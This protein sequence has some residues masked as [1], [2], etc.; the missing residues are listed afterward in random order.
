MAYYYCFYLYLLGAIYH[1]VSFAFLFWYVSY[2]VAVLL[3][4]SFPFKLRPTEYSNWKPHLIL[5]L[6]STFVPLFILVIFWAADSKRY[7]IANHPLICNPQPIPIVILFVMPVS[8]TLGLSLTSVLLIISQLIINQLRIGRHKTS[9]MNKKQNQFI[10]RTLGV[11]ISFTLIC[12]FLIIEFGARLS[13]AKP[14]DTFVELYWACITRYGTN[15][16]CCVDN[17]NQFY[18]PELVILNDFFFSIWGMVALTTLA[19]KEAREFWINLFSKCC[20]CC[21]HRVKSISKPELS[22]NSQTQQKRRVTDDVMLNSSEGN[23]SGGSETG[24]KIGTETSEL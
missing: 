12:L 3:I 23:Q 22:S 5:F 1:Y 24:T 7:E 16:L 8:L 4:L 6:V 2:I 10:V 20:R 9:T 18:H 11:I 13:F 15:T 14:F 17:Y 19:V 21:M